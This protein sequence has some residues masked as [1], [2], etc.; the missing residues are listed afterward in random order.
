MSDNVNHVRI[1]VWSLEELRHYTWSRATGT[2]HEDRSQGYCELYRSTVHTVPG[3]S[4]GYKWAAGHTAYQE[5][6]SFRALCIKPQT[7][8]IL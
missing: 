3:A 5:E 4:A 1:G 6:S 2:S 8:M 7:Y